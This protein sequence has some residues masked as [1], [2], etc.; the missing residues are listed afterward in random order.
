MVLLFF[1]PFFLVIALLILTDSKGGIFYRQE[2][3][4]KDRQ[5]FYLLKFRSMRPMSD[6]KSKITIG[7]DPRITKVGK[8]IRKYKIDE[9]PQLINIIK[10][11]MSVV[12]PRPEVKEY[13]D[14][15]TDEQLKV[16]KIR[17]GLTD[18]SSVEYFNEQELLG[19]AVDP[20]QLYISE[21]MPKKLQLN[22]KYMKSLS[23]R[24][25]MS[26]IFKT[27]LKIFK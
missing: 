6:L 5:P 1:A 3:I 8:F 11:D 19:N 10:G 21:I 23:F 18:F 26:I 4:G 14:L 17:P 13:V 16:L 2:R 20:Q 15:Y 24:T 12:G 7:E 27:V 25:D 22:L 9:F